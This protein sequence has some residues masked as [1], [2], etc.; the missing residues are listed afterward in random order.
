MEDIL[1]FFMKYQLFVY[2]LVILHLFLTLRFTIKAVQGDINHYNFFKMA[3]V[4]F[5]PFIGYYFATKEEQ[6]AD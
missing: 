5:L 6:E 2:P 4:V 3:M 1:P